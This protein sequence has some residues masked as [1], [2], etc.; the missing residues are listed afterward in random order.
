MDIKPH[1]TIRKT[2]ALDR[3]N[4][5][6]GYSIVFLTVCTTTRSHLLANDAAHETLRTLWSDMTRWRVGRYVLMPDHI[7]LF[8]REQSQICCSIGE[9]VGWWKR[10]ATGL[11]G[12]R[13][14]ELWQRGFWDRRIYSCD[15]YSEKI[16]YIR[17]NP[18]RAKL[19]SQPDLWKYQ[20]VVHQLGWFDT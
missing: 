9:W 11:L 13:E 6:P 12:L 17:N 14:G 7:H 16:D 1:L 3:P 2:P 18:V 4:L 15:L 10:I 5:V 8:A 20:G 19:V